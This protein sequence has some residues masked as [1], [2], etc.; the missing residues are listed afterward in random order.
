MKNDDNYIGIIEYYEPDEH[1]LMLNDVE[2]DGFIAFTEL[3]Y[4][5]SRIAILNLYLNMGMVLRMPFLIFIMKLI[6]NKHRKEAC[7]FE[8]VDDKIS[9]DDVYSIIESLLFTSNSKW[10]CDKNFDTIENAFKQ[11]ADANPFE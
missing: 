9:I 1:Y 6:S 3:C 10:K 2:L 11:L 7:K 5:A 4:K 8:L